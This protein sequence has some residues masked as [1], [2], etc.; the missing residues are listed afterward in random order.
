MWNILSYLSKFLEQR[1]QIDYMTYD[2]YHIDYMKSD[3]YHNI[4]CL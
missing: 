4:L 1:Y 3:F 2:F